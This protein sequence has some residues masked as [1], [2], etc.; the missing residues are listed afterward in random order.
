M[1]VAMRRRFDFFALEPDVDVLRAH[2]ESG[3]STN[4]LGEDLYEGFVKLNATLREDLDKHRLIGHSFFMEESF[5]VA[6]LRAK[7][8]RQI[9][10]LLDEYFFERKALE[11][12]YSIEGFWPS[13]AT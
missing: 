2:Y 6:T 3:T 10:P 9:A 11:S 8:D 13:A 5:N 1:D 4:D 12:K 7:W